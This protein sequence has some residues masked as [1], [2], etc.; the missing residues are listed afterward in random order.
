MLIYKVLL[1]RMPKFL[2]SLGT[3]KYSTYNVRSQDILAQAA[4]LNNA[5]LSQTRLKKTFALYK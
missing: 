3:F 4:P 5:E 1:Q 2:F